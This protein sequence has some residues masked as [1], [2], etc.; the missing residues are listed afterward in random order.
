MTQPQQQ[1]GSNQIFPDDPFGSIKQS[2]TDTSPRP[3]E[4]NAFHKRADTDSS[5]TAK[6][7]TLGPR[8]GQ[9]SPGDHIHNGLSSKKLMDGIT[10]TGAKAGNVALTNLLAALAPVLGFTDSTT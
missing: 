10:I 9:A 2:A 6:H 3:Q 1:G 7:H 8:N 4:V 5:V